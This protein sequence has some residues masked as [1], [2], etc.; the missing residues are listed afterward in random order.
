MPIL[1]TMPLI[2]LLLVG[3]GLACERVLARRVEAD[4]EAPAYSLLTGWSALVLV[5]ALCAVAGVPLTGPA[6]AI[7]AVGVVGLVGA[8]PAAAGLWRLAL[9]WLLLL[10]MMAIASVIPP[11]MPDEFPQLLPNAR[12]LVDNDVFPDRAHPNLE[13]SKPD[14]PP[15]LALIAYA[16]G[17]FGGHDV[18][19]PGKM[20]TV[21]LAGAFAV[22]LA[23]QV[24]PRIGPLLAIAMGAL[25][26]TV[27]N[28]FFDPRIALTSYTD[29][30]TGFLLA[31]CVAACWRALDDVQP[32]WRLYAAA[33]A[34]VLVLLR[35]T[36]LVFV[37]A[38][39]AGLLL[40]RQY[41]S[42]AWIVASAFVAFGLWRIYI[43]TAGKTPSMTVRP[44][45]TW[46]WSA[47][48]A[49]VRVLFGE[50]LANHP[51]LGIGGAGF[52][53]AVFV[54]FVWVMR[55]GDR[56]LR[57]LFVI[58]GLVAATW[59]T[60]L[61]WAYA[62][63][64]VKQVLTANSAWRYLSELGPLL[65][66][67]AV[68]AIANALPERWVMARTRATAAVGVAACLV[69]VLATL[70]TWR[71]W[72]ID[73]R[74]PDV[75]AV[76]G[77]T[78]ALATLRVGSDKIAVIHPDEPGWYAEAIDYELRRPWASSVPFRSP[79][80]A[81]A[82]DYRLDLSR[83]DRKQLLE[84]GSVPSFEFTRR[85]GEGW[86]PVLTLAAQKLSGCGN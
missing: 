13:T 52:A 28:P 35:E 47:P 68:A 84:T 41:R 77:M 51:L 67:A 4:F 83:L 19:Y 26:A 17:R 61:A 31:L 36:N 6:I 37:V 43:V 5:G 82:P 73:C 44:V 78:P 1:I 80:Q 74:F 54:L 49:M 57:A 62:A 15:A 39:A 60:F 70:A 34:I 8:G 38:L 29:T 40:L 71:H 16:A 55:A 63:V 65:I 64:F 7:G 14:Y 42:A 32:R 85:D 24:A 56:K 23:A 12:V 48:F 22:A 10:P 21:L 3:V 33:A 46:D 79:A 18:A 25:L 76:R 59:C 30:P 75:V 2:A 69:P 50:R 45:A 11:T 58:A 9:A 86:R 81:L 27:L 72:R 20:F 53:L 66:Y